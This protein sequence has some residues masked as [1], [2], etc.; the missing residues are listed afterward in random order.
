M[1]L[2]YKVLSASKVSDG[3]NE[4]LASYTVPAGEVWYVAEYAGVVITNET[5]GSGVTNYLHA[6][7]TPSLGQTRENIQMA[8]DYL[9]NNSAGS[10]SGVIG[11]YAYEGDTVAIYETD[12]ENS[13]SELGGSIYMRRVL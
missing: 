4:N 7:I 10:S 8:S 1:A 5:A 13:N 6:R 12:K 3:I 11:A 9:G 2:G